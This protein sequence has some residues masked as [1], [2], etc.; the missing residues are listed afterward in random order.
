MAGTFE[1]LLLVNLQM[2]VDFGFSECPVGFPTSCVPEPKPEPRDTWVI[3]EVEIAY[4]ETTSFQEKKGARAGR[5]STK[6]VQ[7]TGIFLQPRL[8]GHSH[9]VSL[10]VHALFVTYWPLWQRGS[11]LCANCVFNMLMSTSLSMRLPCLPTVG[12]NS[13]STWNQWR[14]P[15]PQSPQL[16][17]R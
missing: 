16:C 17:I 3:A 7:I 1:A 12:Q 15:S 11:G 9:S 14:Q 8:W 13:A 4:R 2:L 6:T 5:T 10:S